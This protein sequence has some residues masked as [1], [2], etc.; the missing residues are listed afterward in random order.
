[1]QKEDG[2]PKPAADGLAPSLPF[3]RPYGLRYSQI[4]FA[5]SQVAQIPLYGNALLRKAG[6]I[7]KSEARNQRSVALG[8]L[9]SHQV[10]VSRGGQKSDVRNQKADGRRLQWIGVACT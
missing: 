4:L 10:Q 8:R 1:M 3:S 5:T 2:F 6:R 9:Q 7:Q